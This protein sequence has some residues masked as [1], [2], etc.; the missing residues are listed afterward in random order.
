[1]TENLSLRIV[2]IAKWRKL[3]RKHG[4]IR[5][6]CTRAYG[7]KEYREFGG[8]TV[9]VIQTDGDIIRLGNMATHEDR[10]FLT[11]KALFS[12]ALEFGFTH[13]EIPLF[14]GEVSINRLSE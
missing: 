3:V 4:A 5:V 6:T 1:M 2:P 14:E 9:D 7:Q 10:I 12:F 8:W 13:F 11:T